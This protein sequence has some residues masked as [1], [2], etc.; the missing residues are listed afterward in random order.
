MPALPDPPR[1]IRIVG[2]SGSGKS[3]LAALVAARTGLPRLELDAV[4]WDAE[5]TRRDLDEARGL[6]RAFVA[7][8]PEGWVTDGN[9]TSRLDG[10]LEPGTPG[11]ADV[12]VWIDHPRR[13]VMRR[14]IVRTLRR[15]VT[16]EVLWHGNRERPSSWLRW[17]PEKNI[18]RWAWTNHPVMTALMRARIDAGD[19]VVRLR[20]QREVDAWL[21]S[22]AA[23]GR[24]VGE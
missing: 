23:R 3:H 4:F 22:L 6:V 10:L 15:G 11:G 16:R 18:L 20:G 1:R 17:A 7:A 13:V 14:V 5:W 8:H 24:S 19:P 21:A 12:I 2:T 9:W